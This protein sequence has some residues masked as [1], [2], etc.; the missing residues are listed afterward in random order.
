M[1]PFIPSRNDSDFLHS[2]LRAERAISSHCPARHGF[3]LVE[4]LVVITIIGILIALLLPAVQAAREAARRM[5]CT[6]GLKQMAFGVSQSRKRPWA[7]CLRTVGGIIGLAIPI[8]ASEGRSRVRGATT[9][10]RSWRCSLFT[11]W[12][13]GWR[14]VRRWLFL[15]NVN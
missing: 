15:L 2:G 3:T 7:I 8:G 11:T 12:E 5:Q 14:P 13:K 4:L 9:F 10:F 1:I 6:N